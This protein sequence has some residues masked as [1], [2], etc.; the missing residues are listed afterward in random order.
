[1]I[2]RPTF[3]STPHCFPTCLFVKCFILCIFFVI[4]MSLLSCKPAETPS[5]LSKRPISPASAPPPADRTPE[6]GETSVS[7]KKIDNVEKKIIKEGQISFE[8]SNIDKTRDLI[9]AIIREIGSYIAEDSY[10]KSESRVAHRIV[11][12]VPA[13]N[14]D[15]LVQKIADVAGNIEEKNIKTLDVTEEYVDIKARIKT[16]KA[17]EMQYVQ[18]LRKANKVEDILNI[19]KQLGDLREKIETVEGRMKYLQDRIAYSTLTV[20]YYQKTY[21]PTAFAKRF[22]EGL[23]IGWRLFIKF[24][25]GLVYVWPFLVIILAVFLFHRRRVKRKQR[26]TIE[27]KGQVR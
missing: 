5:T 27:E 12:R 9:N 15:V 3:I 21:A 26:K 25:L 18:L 19:E 10:E 8:T 1:M 23:A 14:F 11:I 22:M 7:D 20:Y 24:C 6:K 13:N 16:K 17:V 2:Q 4:T